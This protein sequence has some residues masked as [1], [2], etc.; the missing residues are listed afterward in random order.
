MKTTFRI[1]S[2]IAL[3]IFFTQSNTFAQ[4]CVAI[5]ST[6]GIC[7]MA[8]HPD[9]ANASG[10]WLFNS[11]S[12]YY[13]SFRHFVGKQEQFQRIALHNN[14][15]NKVY[16][17][18]LTLTRVLDQRWSISVNLPMADNS[19]SQVQGTL[20]KRFSTHSFGIGDIHAAGYYW[21]FNPAKA[22]NGNIQVGLGLKFATGTYNYQDYFLNATG[23]KTLGAVDQSIQL[24][25]GGTGITAE[26]NAYYNLSHRF[27]FYG[28]FY[29]LSSPKDV[30][31]VL[32]STNPAS[33]TTIA[34]TGDV[35]SVPDQMLIR[36]GAS[37]AVN[38][39][40]FSLGVRDDCLPSKDLF[41]NSDGFRR[42]GYIIGAEPG[43]TYRMKKVSLYA[44]CPIAIIRDRTQ[45]VPDKRTTQ[46]TGVY[47]Q[48]DAAFADYV[49][50]VG[51][52]FKF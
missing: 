46:L 49:I 13:K 10:Y 35:L 21:L 44:Y 19:R 16:T 42:P 17:Q 50:N 48:G 15:I 7:T 22:T 32:R 37:L 3:F 26:I 40:D 5:R 1:I 34:V 6:G 25:D 38:K 51:I 45:S 27:G 9:S 41:G 28:N 14:V 47:T 39:F 36:F 33:A 23:G 8:E 18:D 2:V 20:G 43:V 24:G 4:G 31:G 52:T 29:Y 30:N 12:R 11:N